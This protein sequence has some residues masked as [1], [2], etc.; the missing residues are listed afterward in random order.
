MIFTFSIL[1]LKCF[2]RQNRSFKGKNKKA[3]DEDKHWISQFI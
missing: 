2:Q 1:I 3:D